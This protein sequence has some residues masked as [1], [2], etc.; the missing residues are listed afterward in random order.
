MGTPKWLH[1]AATTAAKVRERARSR[2]RVSRGNGVSAG[3]ADK[4][5]GERGMFQLHPGT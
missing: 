4:E 2:G 1:G 5:D 3:A